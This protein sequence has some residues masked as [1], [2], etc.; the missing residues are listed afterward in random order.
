MRVSHKWHWFGCILSEVFKPFILGVLFEFLK[1]NGWTKQCKRDINTWCLN[2]RVS[3]AK[4]A[5]YWKFKSEK[6]PWKRESTKSGLLELKF[7]I[8]LLTNCWKV[9]LTTKSTKT[10][11]IFYFFEM[12]LWLDFSLNTLNAGYQ[13]CFCYL[14]EDFR[15]IFAKSQW[16]NF[17][18]IA[19]Y[20][21]IALF[22]CSVHWCGCGCR[23]R[24]NHRCSCGGL[25]CCEE[26][27]VSKDFAPCPLNE[28]L[29]Q[30]VHLSCFFC[31]YCCCL[32]FF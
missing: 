22:S 13:P 24:V 3:G 2:K 1:W 7:T 21:N 26:Q 19:P 5:C 18:H 6:Y 16:E 28:L 27:K 14:F 29:N 31:C 32:F 20:I 12:W 15:V 30:K 10:C 4:I 23:H 25:L 9:A 8:L 17:C 11:M